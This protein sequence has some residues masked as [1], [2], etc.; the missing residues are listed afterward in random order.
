MEL[1]SLHFLHRIAHVDAFSLIVKSGTSAY[2]KTLTVSQETRYNIQDPWI[3]QFLSPE[4]P[5]SK[6]MS[7]WIHLQI[8]Q[9]LQNCWVFRSLTQLKK[10]FLLFNRFQALHKFQDQVLVRDVSFCCS[11][12]M[13]WR[14]QS[15]VFPLIE[16]F[17]RKS[18]VFINAVFSKLGPRR[19]W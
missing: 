16:T 14:N 12:K 5:G 1:D 7:K 9:T 11:Q 4:L 2:P 10:K 15:A 19:Q 17:R 6:I 18:S 13:D 8:F 3:N